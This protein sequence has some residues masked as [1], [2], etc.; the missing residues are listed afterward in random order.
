M[1]NLILQTTLSLLQVGDFGLAR[2]YG[3]PLKAYTPVVVTL[4]Y[5]APELLLGAKVSLKGRLRTFLAPWPMNLWLTLMW[6]CMHLN[7]F[8]CT[9]RSTPQLWTCGQWAAYLENC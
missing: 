6:V 9:R 3:S 4:W 8:F 7:R 5:R 1:H 2:E